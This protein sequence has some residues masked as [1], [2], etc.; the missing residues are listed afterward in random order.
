M[1]VGGDGLYGVNVD[2]AGKFSYPVAPGLSWY[3][4]DTSGK[5]KDFANKS[6]TASKGHGSADNTGGVFFLKGI[7][8]AAAVP[9]IDGATG[10][11]AAA[12]LAAALAVAEG[13][14]RRR[15]QA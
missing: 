6:Y 4:D 14:C 5:W 9:E 8:A 10:G 15:C 13:R 12:L 1:V 11:N 2:N 7:L 3:F